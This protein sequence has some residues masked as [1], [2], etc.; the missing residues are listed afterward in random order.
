VPSVG[1]VVKILTTGQTSADAG[2]GALEGGCWTTYGVGVI[3][4]FAGV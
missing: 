2:H 4:G 1:Y 3:M